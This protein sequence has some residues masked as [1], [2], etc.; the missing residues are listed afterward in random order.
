V[1]YDP[2]T[3]FAIYIIGILAVLTTCAIVADLWLA[4][5]ERKERRALRDQ[6]RAKARAER[7]IGEGSSLD[8]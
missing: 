2:I 7:M 6:A 4:Y 1:I 3:T 5:E 8:V